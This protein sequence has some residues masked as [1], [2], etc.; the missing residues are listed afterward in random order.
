MQLEELVRTG[1]L[2]ITSKNIQVLG[3]MGNQNTR[4][5]INEH[6]AHAGL[7]IIG[8]HSE[9]LKHQGARVF[10]GYDDVGNILFVNSHS[11]KE[12]S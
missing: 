12:I 3:E 8:F 1:R 7:T 4:S 10:Q 11:Q 9:L 5:L 2:P 6:S